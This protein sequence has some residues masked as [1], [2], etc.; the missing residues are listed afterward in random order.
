[1]SVYNLCIIIVAVYSWHQIP[2]DRLT[3]QEAQL[4]HLP[5]SSC[6]RVQ[7][8][9]VTGGEGTYDDL[10]APLR[11][12]GIPRLIGFWSNDLIVFFLRNDR[13]AYEA[14]YDARRQRNPKVHFRPLYRNEASQQIIGQP[15]TDVQFATALAPCAFGHDGLAPGARQRMTAL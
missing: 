3:N 14:Q 6:F 2:D 4:C 1:V 13:A 7:Q 8:E 9:C 15:L 10:K 11:D 12:G 5:N